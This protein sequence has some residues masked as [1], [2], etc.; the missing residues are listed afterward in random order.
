MEFLSRASA[1][2][3][4]TLALLL[5]GCAS[6]WKHPDIGDLW[7]EQ[8][9]RICQQQAELTV[10]ATPATFNGSLMELYG[11][12]FSPSTRRMPLWMGAPGPMFDIDPTRRMLEEDRLAEACMQAKGYTRSR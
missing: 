5:C 2:A 11:Q 4:I 7:A 1:A 6:E 3:G 10:D 12:N 8:D 9:E